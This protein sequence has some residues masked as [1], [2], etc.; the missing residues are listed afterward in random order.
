MIE[1]RTGR[2]SL[3]GAVLFATVPVT[4]GNAAETADAFPV[5]AD[6]LGFDQRIDDS[7]WSRY[8]FALTN[9]SADQ[10]SVT[11]CPTDAA[12]VLNSHRREE[13]PAFAI[14]FDDSNWSYNCGER[15]LAPGE[16]T[17]LGVFF[18][19]GFAFESIRRASSFDVVIG[20]N[21]LSFVMSTPLACEECADR[22][23][24]VAKAVKAMTQ[25]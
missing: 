16:Q 19:P 21:D 5:T 11:L 3:L 17:V 4:A 9:H 7:R 18:R 14:K 13:V 25:R 23:M 8:D 10:Q 24:P 22:A 12:M 1:Y 2:T 15:E 20:T 6:Y